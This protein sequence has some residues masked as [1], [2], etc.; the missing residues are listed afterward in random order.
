MDICL[1]DPSRPAEKRIH[2]FL[3]ASGLSLSAGV[4]LQ[5]VGLQ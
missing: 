2:I 4:D 1:N 3:L 5:D